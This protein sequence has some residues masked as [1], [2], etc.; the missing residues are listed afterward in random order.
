MAWMALDRIQARA[1]KVRDMPGFE[2]A[3]RDSLAK[4]LTGYYAHTSSALEGLDWR[5]A[6]ER[7]PGAKHS[8]YQIVQHLIFWHE[9]LLDRVAGNSNPEPDEDRWPWPYQPANEAEWSAV[10]A[11]YRRALDQAQAHSKQDPLD[12]LI[13]VSMDMSRYDAI[14]TIGSHNSYHVGQIVLL[15]E[16]LGVW[17][18]A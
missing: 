6:G 5:K 4:A 1:G 16:M 17:P 13:Q 7:P 8:I 11:R 14:R 9:F 3:A 10:L 15:R 18:P 2:A 12:E